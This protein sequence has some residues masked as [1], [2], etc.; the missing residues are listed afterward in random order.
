MSPSIVFTTTP[1]HEAL[2]YLSV[3][4]E[5]AESVWPRGEITEFEGA[6]I[7]ERT[8]LGKLVGHVKEGKHYTVIGLPTR[9]AS[10][11]ALPRVLQVVQVDSVA[12]VLSFVGRH[13]TQLSTIGTDLEDTTELQS[14]V[15]NTRVCSLGRMQRPPIQRLHDGV[16]WL[17]TLFHRP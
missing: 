15:P 5:R 8:I 12:D 9:Y 3:A 4:M 1:L 13:E 14:L 10:V 17:D 6:K 16:P 11:Q 7:R 2:Q